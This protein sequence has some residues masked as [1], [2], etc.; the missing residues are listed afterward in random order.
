VQLHGNQSQTNDKGAQKTYRQAAQ[1]SKEAYLSRQ[2]VEAILIKLEDVAS[3]TMRANAVSVL[4][5]S[6]VN[7]VMRPMAAGKD[8]KRF[9]R[10]CRGVIN[11]NEETKGRE[12]DS[13]AEKVELCQREHTRWHVDE[14]VVVKLNEN[15]RECV[16][17]QHQN[18]LIGRRTRS[19][20]SVVA[21]SRPTMRTRLRMLNCTAVSFAEIRFCS[22]MPRS[23]V[24]STTKCSAM[25]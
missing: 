6:S 7:V 2:T 18:A 21:R 3:E 15:R 11:D 5:Q 8:D 10:S 14:A 17:I 9:E 22:T 13:H 19:A 20:L 23:F 4:T 24:V 1:R 25:K 12:P 16:R